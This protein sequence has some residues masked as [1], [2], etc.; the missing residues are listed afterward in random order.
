[1]DIIPD[2][3]KHKPIY[4]IENYAAI[5]GHYKNDTDVKGISVGR[6]QWCT[7]E[8]VPSVKV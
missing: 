6:A 7:N 8:F 5:D 2:N 1:M 4:V 3:L